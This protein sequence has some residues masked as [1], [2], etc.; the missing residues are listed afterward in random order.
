MA[1]LGVSVGLERQKYRQPQEKIVCNAL[2][3]RS[4]NMVVV[5][6]FALDLVR[7]HK[8]IGS[9]KTRR[10]CAGWNPDFLLQIFQITR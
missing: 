5:R 1:Y 7:H 8:T 10:K 6:R 9:I 4:K 2:V 3:L